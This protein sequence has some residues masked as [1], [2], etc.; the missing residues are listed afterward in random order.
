MG[1]NI[2]MNKSVLWICVVVVIVASAAGIYWVV[3]KDG[4]SLS[5]Y[6]NFNTSEDGRVDS[7]GFKIRLSNFSE[8][9]ELGKGVLIVHGSDI[10]LNYFGDTP[11]EIF[12]EISVNGSTKELKKE[13]RRLRINGRKIYKVIDLKDIDANGDLDLKIDVE[14]IDAQVSI[15]QK[16]KNTEDTVSI[17]TSYPLYDIETNLPRRYSVLADILDIGFLSNG[18]DTKHPVKLHRDLEGIV[19]ISI[20]P[21]Q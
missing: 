6:N 14:S 2:D 17:M 21:S 12:R 5:R 15:I 7:S 1:Y 3:S 13:L 19:G 16:V 9:F 20:T 10:D 18:E 4:V 11:P 8:G